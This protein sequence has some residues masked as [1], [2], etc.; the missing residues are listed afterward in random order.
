[1]E[2]EKD[3]LL[4]KTDVLPNIFLN[5]IKAKKLIAQ[6]KVKSSSQAARMAGISRSAF[7][8]YKDS[9]F[10]Y[11]SMVSDNIIT[12]SVILYDEHGILSSVLS[13]M[14]SQGAN[15]LTIN[16][17]IPVDGVA[18]VSISA[19]VDSMTGSTKALVERLGGLYGVV[20]V[21]NITGK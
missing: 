3:F 15:I 10:E 8:K 16:Q 13:E 4:I 6:G 18:H 11:D 9:V 1:M 5:V 14:S 2:N 19:R 7:Y 21:K 12:L 20:E 17:N